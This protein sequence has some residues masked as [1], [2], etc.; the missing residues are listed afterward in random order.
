M[1]RSRKRTVDESTPREWEDRRVTLGLIIGLVCAVGSAL[2]TNLSFLFKHRGAVAADDV[3]MHH[4]LGSAAALFRSKWFALG[5][6]IAVVAF[7]AHA[8]A[9]SLLPLSLAQAVLS[10]GFVLLAVLAERY[11]GFSLG[12]RQ[13]IGVGVVAFALALLG[14]TGH[15]GG[16]TAEYSV[17]AL[18][19]FESCAI[20]LGLLFIFSHH[21]DYARGQPGVLLGAAAGLGFGTSDVAVKAVSGD[22]LSS[23]PWIILAIA[24]GLFSFYASARSLQVGEGVAVIAVTS[25]AANMSA[26][27]AGVL[28]FGDPMGNDAVEVGARALGF[29][30]VLT[31]AAMMPAPTRAAD[32]MQRKGGGEV[33]PAAAGAA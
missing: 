28:V 24:A 4:P 9:L 10:G 14:V 19:L 5:W 12:R 30:L 31:G 25:V 11:F 13:W 17:V 3:D 27:L 33:R 8:A 21:R 22:P 18:V 29:V 1:R 16:D 6:G 23:A 32:V 2:G 20:A 15:G 26:I 7:G